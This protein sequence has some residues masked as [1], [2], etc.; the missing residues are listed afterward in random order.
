MDISKK[1]VDAIMILSA[2]E[3]SCAGTGHPGIC[4][5][6]DCAHPSWENRDRFVLSAGHG[7]AM[8]YAALHLFGLSAPRRCSR[9][10]ALRPKTSPIKRC[11]RSKDRK[12]IS[13]IEAGDFGGVDK[14]SDIWYN[15]SIRRWA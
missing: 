14:A 15:R 13:R 4:L 6:Y 1:S 7:S 11:G 9:D 3:I 2:D 8:L 10:S 12:R 5:K